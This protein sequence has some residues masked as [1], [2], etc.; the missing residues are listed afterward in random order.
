MQEEIPRQEFYEDSSGQIRK[1]NE[2]FRE[3]P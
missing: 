2:K 1:N 3:Q